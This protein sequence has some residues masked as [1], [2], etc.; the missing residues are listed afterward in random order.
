M[1]EPSLSCTLAG[2]GRR[3]YRRRRYFDRDGVRVPDYVASGKN[4][5][6][7]TVAERKKMHKEQLEAIEK[8]CHSCDVGIAKCNELRGIC[9][10]ELKKKIQE[11]AEKS[12]TYEADKARLQG[13]LA[14]ALAVIQAAEKAGKPAAA[15]ITAVDAALVKRLKTLESEN[16]SLRKSFGEATALM[17]RMKTEASQINSTPAEQKASAQIAEL[18]EKLRV[19]EDTIQ[20]QEQ[21]LLEASRQSATEITRNPLFS[22]LPSAPPEPPQAQEI[23]K[24]TEQLA[25]VQAELAAEKAEHEK[26]KE[27]LK[28]VQEQLEKSKQMEEKLNELI[29]YVSDNNGA[30]ISSK[31]ETCKRAVDALKAD[32]KRW[33]EISE[34][35][36]TDGAVAVYK[37]AIRENYLFVLETQIEKFNTLIDELKKVKSGDEEADKANRIRLTDISKELRMMRWQ[38]QSLVS[39]I[40]DVMKNPLEFSSSIPMPAKWNVDGDENQGVDD[41]NLP[42]TRD[43][44]KSLVTKYIRD[45][46]VRDVL[47]NYL[48]DVLNLFWKLLEILRSRIG[49]RDI[50]PYFYFNMITYLEMCLE[51]FKNSVCYSR[52]GYTIPKEYE[53]ANLKTVVVDVKASLKVMINILDDKKNIDNFLNLTG[54]EF[55]GA[56]QGKMEKLFTDAGKVE[57]KRGWFGKMNKMVSQGVNAILEKFRE[58]KASNYYEDVELSFRSKSPKKSTN[59]SPKKKASARRSPKKSLKKKA[60]ARRSKSP[61]KASKKSPKKA[62]KKSPKKKAS[63]RRSKSP[64]KA[65]K[66]KASK[67]SPKR[68]SR[69]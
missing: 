16:A 1:I 67:K 55:K 50:T 22:P 47:D 54:D 28:S 66:K 15:A 13:E 14:A 65:S 56:I 26:T 38:F 51:K 12:K 23:E 17:D 60:S 37:N 19:A 27:A 30:D 32:K 68:R 61:K 62:S 18:D 36:Q 4:I 63:A 53:A 33:D 69:R 39:G 10:A 34:L 24:L 59:R 20:K 41:H 64:K 21:M 42:R 11:I 29:S 44:I 58:P 25:V 3:E 40:D 35:A 5:P 6:C 52:Q 31:I 45:M 7:L 48:L 8:T 57:P 2:R 49:F 46:I 9:N 43:L